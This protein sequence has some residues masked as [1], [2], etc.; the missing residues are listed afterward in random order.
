MF[1]RNGRS[2]VGMGGGDRV[3]SVAGMAWRVVGQGVVV[4]W[5]QGLAFM[6][7]RVRSDL[8]TTCHDCLDWLALDKWKPHSSSGNELYE[9]LTSS[10]VHL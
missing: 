4:G 9:S 3:G 2:L 5:F 6:V 10:R 7:V 1:P 8:Y